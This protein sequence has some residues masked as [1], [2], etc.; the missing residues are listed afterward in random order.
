MSVSI[1]CVKAYIPISF[2]FFRNFSVE[3][4]PSLSAQQFP[5]GL[6]EAIKAFLILPEYLP[7]HLLW[8]DIR[9]VIFFCTAAW[10]RSSPFYILISMLHNHLN[11]TYSSQCYIIISMLHNYQS[12]KF[13]F[14]CPF[15]F[16]QVFIY[17][18]HVIDLLFLSLLGGAW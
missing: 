11:V 8:E 3:C 13:V 7:S 5:T 9:F 12:C 1:F 18:S 15:N 14:L 4:E 6:K 16:D 17:W 10:L 2:P